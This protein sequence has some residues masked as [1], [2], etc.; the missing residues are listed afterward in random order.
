MRGIVLLH[1]SA[2]PHTARQAQALLREHFHWD[3]F[4]HPPQS[5]DL[6]PFDLFLFPKLKEHLA[7]KRFANS[8]DLKDAS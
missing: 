7:G 4:E 8:E 1:D 5:P 6:E 2:R 3:I